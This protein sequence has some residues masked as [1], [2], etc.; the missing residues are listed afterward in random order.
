MKR[1]P[2]YEKQ[3]SA[4][5]EFIEFAGYEIPDHFGDG[6]AEYDRIRKS[7]GIVDFSY[8]GR[9]EIT[10]KDRIQFL[11][12]ICSNDVKSLSEGSGIEAAFLTTMGKTVGYGRFYVKADSVFLDTDGSAQDGT[13]AYLDKYI[14][15]SYAEMVDVRDATAHLS[16]QGP[17][18]RSVIES[19]TGMDFGALAPLQFVTARIA[20]ADVIIARVSHT[21]EDGYDLFTASESSAAVWQVLIDKGSEFGAGPVGFAAYNVARIEAGIPLFGVDFDADNILVE[22]NLDSAVSY[23]KGCYI[24]QEIIA[25]LHYRGHVAKRIALLEVDSDTAPVT[26]DGVFRGTKEVGKVTSAAVSPILQKPIAMGM[27]KY[28]PSQL[29]TELRIDSTGFSMQ[30]KVIEPPRKQ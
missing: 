20:G 21:G 27:I 9:M 30:A 23:T 17:Q 10:G 6:S 12:S 2:L 18:S 29:G 25:R 24:G 13:K 16:V 22:A 5:A 1:S 11:Q 15:L 26:G 4:G 3:E 28:E 19:I 7:A 8:R 14:K